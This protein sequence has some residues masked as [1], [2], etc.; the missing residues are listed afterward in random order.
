MSILQSVVELFFNVFF[1]WP[2]AIIVPMIKYSILYWYISI[3]VFIAWKIW[4]PS[5]SYV[6][7]EPT[8]SDNNINGQYAIYDRDLK[9]DFFTIRKL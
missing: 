6:P 3:P 2:M 1:F 9:S 4:G 8:R 5:G 7:S